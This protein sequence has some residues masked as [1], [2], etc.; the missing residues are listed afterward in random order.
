MLLGFGGLL[1]LVPLGYA[2]MFGA[3]GC[4]ELGAGGLGI[5]S[6]IMLWSQAIG[7][8]IVPVARAALRRPA[9]VRALRSA[10]LA[11]DPRPARAPACRS[12]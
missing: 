9:A 7:F 5:A 2:L 10:A 4:P 3:V 12:A 8:A 6:A 1:L 11:D